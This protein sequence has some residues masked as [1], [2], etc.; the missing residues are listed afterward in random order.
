M[1]FITV[2]YRWQTYWSKTA[3][4]FCWRWRGVIGPSASVTTRIIFSSWIIKL[5]WSTEVW[6]RWV[7][8]SFSI[9]VAQHSFLV[10]LLK[11]KILAFDRKLKY[12]RVCIILHCTGA[13]QFLCT[14]Q[15][16]YT[17]SNIVFRGIGAKPIF[18]CPDA[19][20][21][22]QSTGP[23]PTFQNTGVKHF[24]ANQRLQYVLRKSTLE[25]TMR[26]PYSDEWNSATCH[27]WPIRGRHMS[28][29]NRP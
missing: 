10:A 17:D 28:S 9:S 29:R 15:P 11:N 26:I 20:L 4:T 6:N 7:E 5:V 24:L 8:V 13:K 12:I 27:S 14:Y 2:S 19:N 18:R 23:N 22:F 21:T 25:R 16:Q 3:P 1:H